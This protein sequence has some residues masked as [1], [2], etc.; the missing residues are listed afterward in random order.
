VKDDAVMTESEIAVVVIDSFPS[1]REDPRTTAEVAEDRRHGILEGGLLVA[2]GLSALAVEG[3]VSAI[4]RTTG[5]SAPV[6]GGKDDEGPI[7]TGATDTPPTDTAAVFAGA[8]LDLAFE[9]SKGVMRIAAG[10]ER[11]IRPMTLV[12]MIPP[13]D[14]AA[15]SVEEIAIRRNEAWR[16][17]RTESSRAAELFADAVIPPLVDAVVDRLDLTDLVIEDVD[18][19]RVIG[20]VDI[21]RIIERVDL[22]AVIS[23]I[24]IDAVA[25]GIDVQRI[26][27]RLDL[28]A[29]AQGVIEELDLPAI[30]RGSTETMAAETV[31]GIRVQGMHADRFVARVVDRT[32]RRRNGGPNGSTDPI[33]PAEGES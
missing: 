22:D 2:V 12:A 24:D 13:V 20:D 29:I 9:A 17:A 11:A 18:L 1:G 25:A 5:V 27:D 19:E 32:L 30:I 33:D 26:I 14:R 4:L 21:D 10:L 16:E 15:R 6:V 28:A 8:A 23:S 31:G 3:I 7:Q